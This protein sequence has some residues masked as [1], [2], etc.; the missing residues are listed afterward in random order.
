MDV[1]PPVKVPSWPRPE[2]SPAVRPV[3]SSSCHNPTRPEAGVG[4]GVGSGVGV[5]V[6]PEIAAIEGEMG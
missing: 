6:A 4:V 5:G 3:P 2:V 1:V